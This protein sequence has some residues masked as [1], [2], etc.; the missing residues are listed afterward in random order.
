MKTRIA[1]K[2]AAP[3]IPKLSA[4]ELAE[5]AEILRL[6]GEPS[7]LRI[8]LTCL[9]APGS[10]GELALRVGIPRSLVSHHLRMLRAS[11]LL[12]STRDG[13]QIIYAPMDDRVRCIVEDLASHVVDA[14]KDRDDD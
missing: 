8:L 11:R 1:T 12:R 13:K 4:E 14:A 6:L 3:Q 2:V 10:V 5:M 9:A 7:R